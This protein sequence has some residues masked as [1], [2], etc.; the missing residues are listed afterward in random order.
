MR[1]PRS[2]IR[3]LADYWVERLLEKKTEYRALGGT[4]AQREQQVRRLEEQIERNNGLIK[5]P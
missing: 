5:A 3:E 4:A 2:E 1:S